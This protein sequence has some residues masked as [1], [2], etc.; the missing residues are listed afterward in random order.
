MTVTTRPKGGLPRLVAHDPAIA[1]LLERL[2]ADPQTAILD[3]HASDATLV[4]AYGAARRDDERADVE[5]GR[6]I[7][8]MLALQAEVQRETHLSA[9][10]L[11]RIY[12]ALVIARRLR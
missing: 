4:C 1:G 2:E 6:K 7:S 5:R 12:R 9:A 3:L 10:E 8:W 11:E